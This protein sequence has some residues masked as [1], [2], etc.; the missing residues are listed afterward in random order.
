MDRAERLFAQLDLQVYNK[1]INDETTVAYTLE[2]IAKDILQKDGY[3]KI[4][5]FTLSRIKTHPNCT[6][7]IREMLDVK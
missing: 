6:D 1:L 4:F 2:S 3:R 7:E 5:A